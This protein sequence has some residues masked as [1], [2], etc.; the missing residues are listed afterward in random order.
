EFERELI[1]EL[2][3]GEANPEWAR[4]SLR[5]LQKP[6]ILGGEP[7]HDLRAPA[8]VEAARARHAASVA[9]LGLSPDDGPDGPPAI[10]TVTDGAEAAR[11]L[12]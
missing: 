12:S 9:E 8:V 2:T 5:P 7:V 4:T 3:S 11:V 6:M 10:P 1:A